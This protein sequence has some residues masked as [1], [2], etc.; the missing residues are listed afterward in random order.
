MT[1][2]TTCLGFAKSSPSPHHH[3]HS[4]KTQTAWLQT[5]RPPVLDTETHRRRNVIERSISWLKPAR[6][7]DTRYEKVAVNFL[8]MLKLA[9]LQRYLRNHLRDTT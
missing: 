6:R 7:V 9:M 2:A 5:S 1:K 8:A 4:R 3:E